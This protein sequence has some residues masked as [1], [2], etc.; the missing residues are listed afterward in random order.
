VFLGWALLIA[1][2]LTAAVAAQAPDVT[3]AGDPSVAS[4]TI[5]ALAVDSTQH[6][7]ER[8]VYLLDDGI[9]RLEPDGRSRQSYRQVVQILTANA[10]KAWAERTF[11]YAP[12]RETFRLNWLRVLRPDGT[13]V[14]AAPAVLQTSDVPADPTV[15]VYQARRVVRASLSGVAPGMLIDWSTTV[16]AKAPPL[17]GDF[18]TSWRTVTGAVTRRSRLLLDVPTGFTPRLVEMNLPAPHEEL[19]GH[20]RTVYRWTAQDIP[21]PPRPQP[22]ATDSNA[23]SSWVFIAAP[24]TWDQVAGWYAGLAK[25]RAEMTSDLELKLASAVSA[26]RTRDDSLRALY[27]WVSQDVR[28]VS[29]ALGMGGYQPRP[30]ADVVKSGFG[31][32]K[33]KATLLL[34]FLGRLHVDAYPVLLFAGAHHRTEFP[35]PSIEAFNHVIVAIADPGGYH[36]VDPTAEWVPFDELPAEDQWHFAVVV[37]PDGHGEPVVIPMAPP[38]SNRF[39]TVVHGTVD[40]SGVMR[41]KLGFAATGTFAPPLR[42]ATAAPRDSARWA[43]TARQL[44]AAYPF[45]K[46]DSL[47]ASD[48]RDLSMTPHVAF[49]VTGGRAFTVTGPIAVLPLQQ[50]VGPAAVRTLDELRRAGPRQFPI[51]VAKVNPPNLVEQEFTFELPAGWQATLPKDV[52]VTG[53]FG[54]YTVTYEQTGRDLVIRRR[55]EGAAGVL[56]PERAGDLDAWFEGLAQDSASAIVIARPDAA[57]GH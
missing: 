29:I 38:A 16:E 24:L 27:R 32:C 57:A 34:A 42:V 31:D 4:D 51:D 55:S 45:A 35:P 30:A 41:A 25:G 21:I 9:I 33:D 5:Y 48:G 49:V 56:P 23:W 22:F 52:R 36:Y 40:D 37:H 19:V 47:D 10:A 12:D 2:G 8:F 18:F 46:S 54:S 50:S 28:Y 17:R 53:P 7:G 11:G 20:G 15:P 44:G 39:T 26:A 6:R 43:A 14:S 13:V 1:P 3:P